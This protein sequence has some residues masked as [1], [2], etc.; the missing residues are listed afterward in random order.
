M[1]NHTGEWKEIQIHHR[2]DG[3]VVA[4]HPAFPNLEG[5]FEMQRPLSLVAMILGTVCIVLADMYCQ[6]PAVGSWRPETGWCAVHL[7]NIG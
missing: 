4:A 3:A 1:E 7:E 5:P 6:P 2:R